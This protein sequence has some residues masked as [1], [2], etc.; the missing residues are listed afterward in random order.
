M[1]L[2][3]ADHGADKLFA[4]WFWGFG[5]PVSVKIFSFCHQETGFTIKSMAKDGELFGAPD[6]FYPTTV[7]GTILTAK[8]GNE[9]SRMAALGRLIARYRPPVLKEIQYRRRC[10]VE[11]AEDLTH[12]FL[13]SKCLRQ[14]FLNKVSEEKGSFRAFL[15]R[16]IINFLNDKLKEVET[17]KRGGGVEHV[18]LQVTD[19]EGRKLYDPVAVE[20]LPDEVIDREWARQ[21]LE[22]SMRRLKEECVRALRGPLFDAL[23]PRLTSNDDGAVGLQE[24]AQRLNMTNGALKVAL[25]R[26]RQRLGE[27][28]AEE[29]KATAGMDG[30]WKEDLKY[31]AGL[32]RS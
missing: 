28:V 25:H 29:A 14:N 18:S 23:K 24:I 20:L 10:S 3:C 8:Q 26:M 1:R 11:E 21:L 32:M 7:W 6:G 13:V 19:E 15:R 2:V 27:I 31:L 16:C 30:D 5:K 4:L 22:L 12:E 17:L 9:I